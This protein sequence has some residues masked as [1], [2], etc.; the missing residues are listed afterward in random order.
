MLKLKVMSDIWDNNAARNQIKHILTGFNSGT[1]FSCSSVTTICLHKWMDSSDTERI[2]RTELQPEDRKHNKLLIPTWKQSDKMSH[3]HREAGLSD[4]GD[5]SRSIFCLRRP[6]PHRETLT[7]SVRT[8][9][10]YVRARRRTRPNQ[11]HKT[12]RNCS[13]VEKNVVLFLFYYLQ[14]SYLYFL[15]TFMFNWINKYLVSACLQP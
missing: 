1:I 2:K 11:I 7:S 15:K 6:S 4:S 8:Q 12:S 5:G 3:V 10:R 13:L 14:M 9:T